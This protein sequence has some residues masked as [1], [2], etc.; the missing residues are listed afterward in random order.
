M[1]YYVVISSVLVHISIITP[2]KMFFKRWDE[3]GYGKKKKFN[4]I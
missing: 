2:F 1:K 3:L 4:I